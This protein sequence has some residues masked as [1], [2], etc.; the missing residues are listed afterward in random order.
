[1]AFELSGGPDEIP[2]LMEALQEERDP[3]AK[4]RLKYVLDR[5]NKYRRTP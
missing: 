4:D 5:V 2:A 3:E 1:M